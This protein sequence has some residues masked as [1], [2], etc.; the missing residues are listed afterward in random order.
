MGKY[1]DDTCH[2]E[3]YAD[4]RGGVALECRTEASPKAGVQWNVERKSDGVLV[5]L[6]RDMIK[7]GQA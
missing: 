1:G 3:I 5:P 2:R 6:R 4:E 7:V